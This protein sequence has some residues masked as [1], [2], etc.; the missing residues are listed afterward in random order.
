MIELKVLIATYNQSLKQ[1][2]P[3]VAIE[4]R[5]KYSIG[6]RAYLPG[7]RG[8][9]VEQRRLPLL[10]LQLSIVGVS[11]AYQRAL[12]LQTQLRTNTFKWDLWPSVE[13]RRKERIKQST[14]FDLLN[15]LEREYFKD[16][17]SN[18]TTKNTWRDCYL[19]HYRRVSPHIRPT[20]QI[21]VNFIRNNYAVD[22]RIRQHAKI[23]FA[24][25]GRFLKWSQ[26]DIDR[27]N[28]I[29]STY[30]RKSRQ[31][32]L[33]EH[34]IALGDTLS[35]DVAVSFRLLLTYGC[36]P[37]EL[38]LID[39]STLDPKCGGVLKIK[40][41]GKSKISRLAMPVFPQL[42]DRWCLW[43]YADKLPVSNSE[44]LRGRGQMITSQFARAG[45]SFTPYNLRHTG[46]SGHRASGVPSE[47][48]ARSMGHLTSTHEQIYLADM[49]EDLERESLI[50]ILADRPNQI[51]VDTVV[52][53]DRLK[54][55]SNRRK[56]T[57][58]KL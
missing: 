24:F 19:T 58:K 14:L 18:T 49:R 9:P 10:D 37:H 6:L 7:R 1:S 2:R 32:E 20:P 25:L 27:I 12:E 53:P 16:R 36:R 42:Y 47:I 31:L 21:V 11:I 15:D 17:E 38:F 52:L 29:Q 55:T 8:E 50:K 54:P 48:A 35:G 34:L 13:S 39:P 4:S 3:K 51:E 26:L 56:Q 5:G 46:A 41:G 22:S 30:Q 28:S 57:R 43:E 33:P 23:A 44:T 45:I 40:E